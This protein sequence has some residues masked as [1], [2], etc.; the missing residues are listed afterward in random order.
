MI[1]R[2]GMTTTGIKSRSVRLMICLVTGLGLMTTGVIGPMTSPGTRKIGGMGN[3]LV[4]LLRPDFRVMSLRTPV[5]LNRHGLEVTGGTPALS[6]QKACSNRHIRHQSRLGTSDSP[7][8]L[9]GILILSFDSCCRYMNVSQLD[10][11]G[12]EH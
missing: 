9:D 1:G 5:R 12:F 8:G 4:P 3:N 6:N 11:M 2:L 7:D 10:T